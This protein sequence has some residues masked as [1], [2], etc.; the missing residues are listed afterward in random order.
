MKLG[1]QLVGGNMKKKKLFNNIVLGLS[2]LFVIGVTTANAIDGFM[3]Y[4]G[5][6][7]PGFHKEVSGINNV[8]KVT[9][10][11]QYYENIGTI[12]LTS[13][14]REDIDVRVKCESDNECFSLTSLWTK[15]LDKNRSELKYD[16]HITNS[17]FTG[18]YSI[19]F[20]RPSYGPTSASHSGS[21]YLDEKMIP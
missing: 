12:N 8:R 18:S 20:R 14:A 2:L 19:H 17:G 3:G 16:N 5:V 13:A 15:I 21:W 7:V 4:A 10:S 1:R 6:K 11:K 9:N